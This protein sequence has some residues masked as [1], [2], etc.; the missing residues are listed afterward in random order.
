MRKKMEIKY[1]HY[2]YWYKDIAQS[3]DAVINGGKDY[4]VIRTWAYV[5]QNPGS[6]EA[7]QEYAVYWHLHYGST[8][9]EDVTELH[10]PVFEKALISQ[11]EPQQ[12]PD[13]IMNI[14]EH[15][16]MPVHKGEIL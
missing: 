7:I 15:Q 16:D 3:P 2:K 11:T 8:N 13:T 12:Q 14:T 10:N 1:K 4:A 5:P 6:L 9:W